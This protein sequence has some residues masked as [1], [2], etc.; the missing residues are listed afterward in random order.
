MRSKFD[1]TEHLR[2]WAWCHRR[3]R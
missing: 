1:E 2:S 3:R